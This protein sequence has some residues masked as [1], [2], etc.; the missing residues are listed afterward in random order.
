MC[1]AYRKKWLSLNQRN[2]SYL[3][4]VSEK[5]EVHT[6]FDTSAT[7]FCDILHG[8]FPKQANGGGFQ[9]YKHYKCASNSRD[10]ELLS[11]LLVLKFE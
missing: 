5:S 6:E 10:L 7:Q 2:L 1:L 9:C 4:Q 11:K 3:R 8:A